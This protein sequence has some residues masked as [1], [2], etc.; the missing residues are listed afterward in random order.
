[1]E[2]FRES[3]ANLID[4]F[5][6]NHTIPKDVVFAFSSIPIKGASEKAKHMISITSKSSKYLADF[7]SSLSGAAW[8]LYLSKLS[9]YI[10]KS[11]S[12]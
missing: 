8:D 4:G 1:L 6:S 12:S 3:A 11:G 10:K 5:Y 2:P 7:R 9:K